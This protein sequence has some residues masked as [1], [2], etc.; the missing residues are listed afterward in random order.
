MFPKHVFITGASS[1][2]GLATTQKLVEN[3]YNVF[4]AARRTSAVAALEGVTPVSLDLT[5]SDSIRAA[6][7]SV[8]ERTGGVDILI[9][10][11][12]Y[13]EFGAIEE[14][15]IDDARKQMEVNVFGAM[16]LTQL[17][18]PHMREVGRGR[19]VNVSSVAGE[20]SSPLAGWYHASK[21]ALEALSDSLRGEVAQ[22]GISVVVVQPSYVATDWHDNAM[23]T[24]GY[25]SGT[26]PYAAM[27]NSQRAYF[28]SSAV[29]K[30]TSTVEEVAQILY[31]A[32]TT[33]NPKTRYR[34][35]KGAEL[36]VALAALAPDRV[37][38]ALTRMQFGYGKPA[39]PPPDH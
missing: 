14:T 11:A 20:F 4:G 8:I 29:A 21:F 33:P 31:C 9:N 6:A 30:Q 27:V 23:K 15:H 1:G 2:I 28:A 26:G 10:C 22:F 35:G 12:G 39:S 19:I 38:D 7:N 13:G 24:L 36:A 37:F 32:A 34:V 25:A 18:L 3:G 16:E 5:N 17:M